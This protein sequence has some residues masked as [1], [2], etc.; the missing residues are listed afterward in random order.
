MEAVQEKK[1]GR[2]DL[3]MTTDQRRQIDAAA[4]LN[5]MTVSQWSLSRLMASARHDLAEQRLISLSTDAFDAFATL[6]DRESTSPAVSL[7]AESTRWD[8]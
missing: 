5:G 6:L 2:L 7:A 1:T 3:R 8:R 4:R